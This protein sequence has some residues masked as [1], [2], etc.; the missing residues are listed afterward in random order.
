MLNLNKY[1]TKQ[2]LDK[3]MKTIVI[4]TVIDEFRKSKRYEETTFAM[5]R[6]DIIYMVKSDPYQNEFE[7][8]TEVVQNKLDSLNP[9]T[10]DVFN[11]YNVDGF[12][13]KEIAK[14]LN[15]PEGTC[16]YHYSVAKKELR[17]YINNEYNLG[18][19]V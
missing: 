12:K 6:N 18:H 8:L 1:D 11:L 5:D 10:K 7:G 16:H 9:M 19:T 13:H 3:W 14:M 4:N 15:I 2:P 17:E